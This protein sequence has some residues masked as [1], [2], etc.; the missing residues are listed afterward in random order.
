VSGAQK[1]HDRPTRVTLDRTLVRRG[2][3]TGYAEVVA[4]PGEPHLPREDLT[5]RRHA[6]SRPTPLLAFVQLSDL[7]VMDAQSPA[8]AEF[9]GRHNDPGEEFAD[10]L[11]FIQQYRPQEI[12]TAHVVEAMVRA[13]NESTGG[14][15]GGQPLAFAICTGDSVDNTQYNE[16]RWQIDLLDGGPIIPDSGDPARFEGVADH[17]EYD[18]RYWHPEGTPPGAPDDQPRARYGFPTVPGLLDAA[19][20]PFTATGLRLPWLSVFGNHDGLLSGAIPA[21]APGLNDL[22]VGDQKSLDLPAGTDVLQLG[23]RLA[24][25]D[26]ESL[27]ELFSGPTRTVTPDP[28]RRLL[29]RPEVIDE[30]F[31]TTGQPRGHGFTDW[32]RETG[33]AYYGFDHGSDHRRVRC[34][35]LDTVNPH[36]G[37]EGSLDEDQ[38]EWLADELAAAERLFVLFSHHPVASMTNTRAP[39]GVR[40]FDGVAV[41]ALLLDHPAA[42]LWVNGHTHRNRIEAHVRPGGGGFW[43]VSTS[44]HV[45]WPQQARIVELFDNGDDTL[46][47]FTTM[48]DH[49]GTTDHPTDF[50]AGDRSPLALAAL[51]RELSANDWQPLR[52]TSVETNRG[53]PGDRNAELLVELR[54]GSAHVQG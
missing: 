19:R 33:N 7:H 53:G 52:G 41:R 6:S 47:I 43:E 15:V 50:S 25:L 38:F 18:V 24:E 10:V 3:P 54:V 39:G 14:P 28:A 4:A 31:C 17:E 13:V 2:D 34:L 22:A 35:V 46:S 45:D 44:S 30:H 8:R 9:L 51:S 40:R 49:A 1:T 48:V 29:S 20:A 5:S 42:V 12:L 16:L 37:S 23:K 32:N 21:S 11:D 27:E 26:P 36:G